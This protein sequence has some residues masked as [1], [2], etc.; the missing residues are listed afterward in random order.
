MIRRPPRS[1]LFPYTTLFRSRCNGEGKVIEKPCRTCAGSGHRP[2]EKKVRVSIPGGVDS[3]SQIRLTGEGE[4]GPRGG[5]A[6]DLYIVIQVKPHPVL[7]RNGTD[8][9][10]NRPLSL[11]QPALGDQLETPTSYG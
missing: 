2:G 9:A 8:L 1:T 11:A 5:A 7:K 10:K 6:G 3:G 4:V